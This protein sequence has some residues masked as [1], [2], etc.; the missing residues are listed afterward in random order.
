MVAPLKASLCF[1]NPYGVL[2]YYISNYIKKRSGKLLTS[3]FGFQ[4]SAL[5]ISEIDVVAMSFGTPLH[6]NT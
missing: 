2:N 1:V 4:A 3:L 6:L 5:V